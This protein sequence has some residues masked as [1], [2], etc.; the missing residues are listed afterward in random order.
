MRCRNTASRLGSRTSILITLTPRAFAVELDAGRIDQAPPA[1]TDVT[2]AAGVGARDREPLLSELEERHAAQV[3]EVRV[4]VARLQQLA[5]GAR[6]QAVLLQLLLG[7]HP[8]FL[9]LVLF[10]IVGQRVGARHHHV[11]DLEI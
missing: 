4:E 1:F 11:V 2:T 10:Q 5:A 7:L 3:A 6:P 8:A 9:D